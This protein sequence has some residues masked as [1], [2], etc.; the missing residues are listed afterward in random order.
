MKVEY[1]QNSQ[2]ALRKPSFTHIALLLFIIAV[3]NGSIEG[4]I[5]Q[6]VN[7]TTLGG[8]NFSA[9]L[10][11][12][13][14]FALEDVTLP[15]NA[16]DFIVLQEIDDYAS[17]SDPSFVDVPYSDM[18]LPDY[19]NLIIQIVRTDGNAETVPYTV[20][21]IGE[22]F[23]LVHL[24]TTPD[25]GESLR[26]LAEMVMDEP[27]ETPLE[28]ETETTP[29]TEP[30]DDEGNQ[31]GCVAGEACFADIDSLV[32]AD[33]NYTA[34]D[35]EENLT[36][37]GFV[38]IDTL[39]NA[40]NETGAVPAMPESNGTV[41]DSRG[42]LGAIDIP[43][44][45]AGGLDNLT[46]MVRGSKGERFPAE[47]TMSRGG[48]ERAFGI[49][50]GRPA[51]G[52]PGGKYSITV[53]PQRNETRLKTDPVP[54][55]IEQIRLDGVELSSESGFDL[56]LEFLPPNNLTFG[57]FARQAFAI[58][59]T[60][61]NFTSGQVTVRAK[62]SEL[63]KCAGWDFG[64]RTCSG[65]WVKQMD[66]IPGELYTFTIGPDDPAYVE[67]NA[68]YGAPRCNNS[69][70][71]C[72]AN[73]S[74]LQSRDTLGT[75]EPN[76]PN[77]IDLCADG[78]TGTYL[79]D[80]SVENITITDLNST[81]FNAGDTV[82]VTAWVY[83]F[84]G[85]ADNVN[86]LYTSSASSPAWA[87][88]GYTDPCPAAGRNQV[89]KVFR[90]DSVP[91][92]H[93]VRVII[94]YNGDP[95]TTCGGG[96]YDDNDDV[97]FPVNGTEVSQG[98]DAVI[99]YRSNTGVFALNSP[100]VRFWNSTGNG[101][102]G[103]EIELPSAGSPVRYAAA[104][105]SPISSKI[106]VVT[107]SDDGNLDG[108][109]CM[110]GCSRAGSWSNSS[111]IGN[112]WAAAPAISS[113]RFDIAFETA[114]GDLM[115]TY[116]VVNVGVANDLG[117]KVLPS[118]GRD[119]TGLT[120]L[121]INDGTSA[122]DNTNSWVRMDAKLN[123]SEEI[124]LTAY[125]VTG[126][127]INAWI[128]NGTAWGNQLDVSAASTSTG[129]YEALAVRYASDGSKA[130]VIGGTGLV[131]V[132]NSYYWN[133]TAWSANIPFTAT[134]GGTR[135]VYWAN[136][137]AD[138]SSDDMLAV[139]VDSGPRVDTAYWNGSTWAVTATIDTPDSATTRV[140]DFEWNRTGSVGTLVW[141]T[142]TTGTTLSQRNCRPQCTVATSTFSTY[143]GTGA[144][145]TMFR[146]PRS[147]GLTSILSVRVNSTFDIG[148]FRYDGTGGLNFSNYGD[149]IITTDTTVSTY[150]AYRIAFNNTDMIPPRINFTAPT[151]GNGTVIYANFT[152]INVTVSDNIRV[153]TV[154]L[155]WNGTNQTMNYTSGI[156]WS[157]NKTDLVP[158]IY[159]YRACANDTAG[160]LNCT[161]MRTVVYGIRPNVTVIAPLGEMYDQNHNVPLVINVSTL[162]GLNLT[163]ATV[164]RPDGSTQNVTLYRYP[165]GDDFAINSLGIDWF[166][167]N[168]SIGPSQRCVADI[169]TT[170]PG[171][172]FTSI[173]GDGN[174]KVFTRC[175]LIS[176]RG[177]YGDFDL[178]V[179][180][181]ILASG[182]DTAI[183]MQLMEDNSS[184]YASKLVLLE[185]SNWTGPGRNYVF[186]YDRNTTGYV[187]IRPTND[188]TGR[189][190][191]ARAGNVFS[192]YTWNNTDSSWIFENS[193]YLNLSKALFIS[194]ESESIYP[195][196]G[197]MNASWGNLSFT[198][199]NLSVGFFGATDLIGT[200]NVSFYVRDGLGAVNSSQRTNFTV[201]QINDPPS[202]PFIVA[203]GF[204][205][206]VYGLYNITWAQVFDEE[207]DS[208]R[209]NVT[210][211]NA[212]LSFNATIISNYGDNGTIRYTWNTTAFPDGTYSMRVTVY[213][214][215][216]SEHYSAAY[217]LPG[218]FQ[219]NN[220]PNAPPSVIIISPLDGSYPDNRPI[221]IAINATDPDGINATIAMIFHPI[222]N[223]TQN[224]TLYLPRSG[225]NFGFNTMGIGWF[226]ENGSIGPSQRCIA[227]IDTTVPGKA[228][229]S[230]SGDGT[231]L[232]D[233]LCSIVS[234]NVVYGDFDA[235]ISFDI[236]AEDGTDNA[237]N[238]QIMEVNS[239]SDA[240][241]LAFITLSN[242]TGQGR[243]YEVFVDDGSSSGYIAMRPTE[244]TVGK[245]RIKR[246]GDNFSFY[247]W[248]NT[249]SSWIFENSSV[250]N[251]SKALFFAFESESAFSGWGTMNASWDNMSLSSA[252]Y[253]SNTFY[254]PGHLAV[255]H[256]ITFYVN[257]S[258]GA[259]N[260]TEKT[261]FIII[262]ANNRPSKPFILAPT[263]GAIINGLYD[264]VWSTVSDIDN[265][266]VRFNITLLNSDGSENGSIITDY[267]NITSNNYNWDTTAFPD[268]L[269]SLRV[270]V[271]ENATSQH[272]SNSYTLP[273][274][275]RINNGVPSVIILSPLGESHYKGAEVSLSINA[276]DSD[277]IDAAIA[278]VTYPNGSVVNVTLHGGQHGDNFS[279]DTVGTDWR[280]ENWLTGPSQTC[281]ADID[282]TH[283][284][285]AFTSLSGN[286]APQTDTLCSLIAA[287]P[288]DGDFDVSIS[289]N[290]TSALG[291]DGALNFQ[292]LEGNSSADSRE[293]VYI[294][295][296]NWTGL[297]TNYEVFVSGEDLSEY[298]LRRPTNDTYG[299]FRITREVDNFTFYT[300]NY[301]G[302]AW[303]YE[304]STLLDICRPLYLSFESESA[305]PG[306]GT[307]NVT[308]DDL[309]V[310]DNNATFA[311]FA[312]TL[313]IGTYNV[314][315]YVNDT[316]G[317]LNST[318][319]TNFTILD[320]NQPPSKPY[321]LLPSVGSTVYGMQN[322]TWS[323]VTD[324]EHD[325]LWFNITLLN[326]DGSDNATVASDY[327]NASSVRYLW[328]TAAW[329]DG[330]FS[331][332]VTV[333]ENATSQHLSNSYTLSGTF[334]LDNTPPSVIIISP[335]GENYTE[336]RPV[337][338]SLNI[339]DDEETF[340]IAEVTLPNGS[341]QNLTLGKG[342]Q[343]DDFAVD[344]SGIN[345]SV[346]DVSIGP[347]QTCTADIDS[348][349][350]G[351]AYTSL[352]GDGTPKTDTLCSFISNKAVDGDFD[353]QID[354]NIEEE[355]GTDHALN[356]QITRRPASAGASRTI[357]IALSN[358]TGLGRN[359]E[360]FADDGNFSG[361]ILTRPT[362]DTSGKMRMTRVG[363]YFTFYTWNNSANDWTEE[364]VSQNVFG[365]ARAV[366][367][368]FESETAYPGWGDLGVSWDNFTVIDGNNTFGMFNDTSALGLYN[369]TFY[370]NDTNGRMNDTE[371][372]NFTIVYFDTPPSQP[373]LL[374][375]FPGEYVNGS[376]NITWS[377]VS[378]FDGDSLRFNITLLNPDLTYNDTLASDYGDINTTTFTWN[379]LAYPDEVYSMEIVVYENETT[380]HLSNSYTMLGNFTLDHTAPLIQFEPPTDIS[381]SFFSG[382]SIRVNVS[383]SD[384][385]LTDITIRL[386]N[387]SFSLINQT[388]SSTSPLY[389]V[390]TGL[391]DG[392]YFFNATATD[393]LGHVNQTETRNVT[394][395]AL[396]IYNASASPDPEGFGFNVSILANVTGASVVLVGI[397]PPG[398]SQMNHTMAQASADHYAYNFSGWVNGSYSY[399]IYA[400]S[401][402]GIWVNGSIRYFTL[403]QNVSI[404]ARTL[405]DQYSFNQ[406]INITDPEFINLDGPR[407]S[408]T[409][410]GDGWMPP[411]TD[412]MR[413]L[414][415]GVAA[416]ASARSA[417]LAITA[418]VKDDFGVK[419]VDAIIPTLGGDERVPLSLVKGTALDGVWQASWIPH[420]VT[421]KH[422]I[423][424]IEAENTKR[425][426]DTAYV[427]VGDPP[428]LWVLPIS[429]SDPDNQWDNEFSAR[430]G[431]THTYASDNSNPGNGWGS[432]IVFNISTITSDRVRVWGD[433][434]AQV[435][436]VDI[437]VYKD[438][439]WENVYQ[440]NISNLA[441]SEANFTKGNVT[442]GRFR[443]NYT[444]GGYI[445]WL[446]EFQFYNVSTQVNVPII[447]TRAA[448]SVEE[449]TAIIHTTVASDGGDTCQVRFLYGNASG[450]YTES[451]PWVSDLFTGSPLGKLIR[452]LTN[453]QVYYYIAQVNNSAGESNGS[454]LFFTTG[455]PPAGWLS[456]VGYED[457][458]GRWTN[459]PNAFDDEVSSETNSYHA[460]DDI[461]GP[462][463]SY[464]YLNRTPTILNDRIR[465]NA[466]ATDVDMVEVWI[467]NGTW[468]P[469]YN[470]SFTDSVWTTAAFNKTNVSQARIRFRAVANNRGFE[471]RLAGFDFFKD[472]LTSPENQSKVEN[473]GP[474]HASCYLFMKTQFWNGTTWLDDDVVINETAPR[475]LDAP[476][477]LKLD[478]IWNPRNYST[479][480]LS[481]GTGH[482]RVYSACHDNQSNVLMNING[483]FV[484]N[485]YNFTY[486][487]TS[488]RVNITSPINGTNYTLLSMIPIRINVTEDFGVATVKA[489]VSNAVGYELLTLVY[490]ATSGLW[491]YNFI[492]TNYV[493]VYTIRAIA[494]DVAGNVND[495]EYVQVNVID[496]LFPSVA[497]ISPPNGF[498]N[499]SESMNVTFRCNAT[500]NYDV[501]TISLYLT[502]KNN[503]SFSFNS[504]VDVSGVYTQAAF[505]VNLSVG[506]YTWNCLANDS[507]GHSVWAP[508]NWSLM[509]N[510]PNC[511]IIS[512]PGT[513]TQA[514]NYTGAPNNASPLS[515]TVCVKIN[516]SNVIYDCNGFGITG[517]SSGSTIGI[518]IA[519]PVTN[520]TL[521]NCPAV[522][523][524][525]G[526]IYVLLANATIIQ[527]G[528]AFNNS[529]GFTL[530]Q[531]SNASIG[532]IT[533]YNNSLYGISLISSTGNNITNSNITNNTFGGIV[534]GAGS[535]NNSISRSYSCFNDRNDLNNSGSNNTGS[536]DRCD[537]SS[538]WTENGFGG[539]TYTCSR[540]WH[541]FFGNVTGSVLLSPRDD[542]TEIFY[543]WIWNGQAGNIY[544]VRASAA[545]NWAS[546][547]ALGRN[548]TIQPSTNDFTELDTLL[549]ISSE[550]DRIRNLFSSDGSSPLDT[551]NMTIFNKAVDYVPVANSSTQGFSKTGIAWDSSETVGNGQ[552]DTSDNEDVVFMTAINGTAPFQYDIRVPGTLDTY[553]VGS[554][555]EFWVE[556]E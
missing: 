164:T 249:G 369:V 397:T 252:Q 350:P 163:I 228:Y 138:P 251:L 316:V 345:W 227:D 244:D 226:V 220:T 441:W 234:H 439:K 482:Y 190:R 331:I 57:K 209:F 68:T 421:G 413:E 3:A 222:T 499:S 490:N 353:I 139:F 40:T 377:G 546:L 102:W 329:P 521:K 415:K 440:G 216:T 544:A 507:S 275:F 548:T 250:L 131:G 187:T 156:A 390:F 196:W 315:F 351:K 464:L 88:V 321:I 146:N 333:F 459:E 267:G 520:V 247:T 383:A 518:L 266:T 288:L 37:T 36:D 311:A 526:G 484:N 98:G 26:F 95:T 127:D 367:V 182:N 405:T 501:D 524:Y 264:I 112:V 515:G 458:D 176:R 308:W 434:E 380:E 117:Y 258:R 191:I 406:T 276:S 86:F 12:N 99:A 135:D 153:D 125:D 307:V 388:S 268:G 376:Y 289:F 121:Y 424:R 429:D 55:P 50:Q 332:R 364:A 155:E 320:E 89:S 35:I 75:P 205:A 292:I 29:E 301:S 500:D 466:K 476:D 468:M 361:Y 215:A 393:L 218:T 184:A 48:V 343:S 391:Q 531:S 334:F 21:S 97:V 491:E 67:Y 448:T 118:S 62:G 325:T 545:T 8:A 540:V 362:D 463:S 449:T 152:F 73:S 304:N 4:V 310:I 517:N 122:L 78:G 344:T 148:S 375:P 94:Q 347:S 478:I 418:R 525:T 41:S 356:F 18:L 370:V 342:Q 477:V 208:L 408:E 365:F 427:S 330:E 509:I 379:T 274:T 42:L 113:R 442:A 437:D 493:G 269:Y 65:E 341:M 130:V 105:W 149:A 480:N 290:L 177:I 245:F 46:F 556:L 158:G 366:Y 363:D 136:L 279:S 337:S 496:D 38:D 159:T 317:G 180:F 71:P 360:I 5:L 323:G 547:V 485:T 119:F 348:T 124:A 529:V 59:P 554:T 394:V 513:Y 505:T 123:N 443:Y 291:D 110:G 432:F 198:H 508:A 469:I 179:P 371:K 161:E 453:G 306:W 259:V 239:S 224:I 30:Q 352:T 169:D 335:H 410:F 128:W 522:S 539:C 314:T 74:T 407:L 197:T 412:D 230:L 225:D 422:F 262:D 167:E 90:L 302:S 17:Q 145:I 346:E 133:G 374:A 206:S 107:Q 294:S 551:R 354:F 7:G 52:I 460:I 54:A 282:T 385:S 223:T 134:T 211:L 423:V 49:S 175:S 195:G 319:K 452:N 428:G 189:F 43:V 47:I 56:G 221:P 414:A 300:W 402:S 359:Y 260:N 120:E 387:S 541:R 20:V 151:Y 202:V 327:G 104:A 553:K 425:V 2:S 430:D 473:F 372:T 296:S 132:V 328:D 61:L 185:L 84:D 53:K 471:F 214:N 355:T 510:A 283:P 183:N 470:A 126:S 447:S 203:P 232:S 248:N 200:Y 489:N 72:I 404:Q 368:S 64:S 143:T 538:G 550:G 16:T 495:T 516:A 101:S 396:D 109:V 401:S 32:D 436:S 11:E 103:S 389:T 409:S 257:D 236:L 318:E 81:T 419:R 549:G 281:I 69:T 111:N 278:I 174:P 416:Q 512:S 141:D 166:V 193:T 445:Y 255:L 160:N 450:A 246:A 6:D 339:T 10:G 475:V 270:T 426:N 349:M 231:P 295:L 492:N 399:V 503:Q 313:A 31:T 433:Y 444:V 253:Y 261:T 82:N 13:G 142:D 400:N 502:D 150:E 497:L 479:N 256:N 340:A 455:T 322:V 213:E 25:E 60:K 66:L 58:D 532:G 299:K 45:W 137:K 235:N 162:Y 417:G 519:G 129:Q 39:L 420:D 33:G 431:D 77:T 28:N 14:S 63:L 534:F 528:T 446:Y 1:R 154:L 498:S 324:L 285:K 435:G 70:S 298:I 533:S 488:P 9:T 186:V 240:S 309:S 76:Q 286:G 514:R 165:Q 481:F 241:S 395:L 116:S 530:N 44:E 96:A 199:T 233:T 357:F 192:F 170:V 312:D 80:E 87:T 504:T 242:W 303:S 238:F 297:G 106:V 51:F 172:A 382:G 229:T 85:T 535:A 188:I 19:S 23:A 212:N 265:D 83:C 386:Y 173:T 552:F 467:Y 287:K 15:E 168:I 543:R 384:P 79:T 171:K 22:T 506:T 210:L 27:D 392:L 454:E 486:D 555:V 273:G 284:G 207:G 456:P 537:Y 219:I 144:W 24:E 147:T 336:R 92:E 378:D 536:F 381:G 511:P 280:G 93:A 523:N 338:L 462:W 204:G 403:F 451:T 527:N 243:N 398:G 461:Y 181:N 254:D 100:K 472:V 91:G 201:M 483:S 194:F 263:P 34:S 272:L 542:N 157:L 140:A 237:I 293:L 217:T 465:F 115:L 108:Y 438:D 457:P 373:F 411:Q 271:F 305:I 114:T 487:I 178:S 358:W 494:T 326:P 277:G 474:L